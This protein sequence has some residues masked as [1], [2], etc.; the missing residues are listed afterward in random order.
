[1]KV[2]SRT[3]NIFFSP[4]TKEDEGNYTCLAHNDVGNQSISGKIIVYGEYLLF[5]L[6]F[7]CLPGTF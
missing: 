6:P 2:D 1:M 5:E 3:G 4:L 7:C